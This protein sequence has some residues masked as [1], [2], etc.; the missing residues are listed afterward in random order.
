MEA[1]GVSADITVFFVPRAL[2]VV[3]GNFF[4]VDV[5][6]DGFVAVFASRFAPLCGTRCLAFLVGFGW[7]VP[8]PMD[9]NGVPT[10]LAGFLVPRAFLVIPRRVVPILMNAQLTAAVRTRHSAPLAHNSRPPVSPIVQE[11]AARKK[12]LGRCVWRRMAVPHARRAE[13]ENVFVIAHPR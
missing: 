4:P 7:V 3:P 9:A 8:I 2:L 1:H 6:P 5:V 10:N 12:A 13:N 11:K